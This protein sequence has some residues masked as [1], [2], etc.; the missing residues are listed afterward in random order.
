MNDLTR[1][2][3]SDRLSGG[4]RSNDNDDNNN[5]KKKRLR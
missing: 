4:L 3:L 1:G 5:K 2:T